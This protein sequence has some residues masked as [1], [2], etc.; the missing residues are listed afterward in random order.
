MQHI[1]NLQATLHSTIQ[2]YS[3]PFTINNQSEAVHTG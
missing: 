3:H 2:T 1:W